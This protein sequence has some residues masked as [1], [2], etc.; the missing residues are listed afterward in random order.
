MGL[1]RKIDTA[2]A[3]SESCASLEAVLREQLDL[4]ELSYR[5]IAADIGWS[6]TQ[7]WLFHKQECKLQFDMLSS[8]ANFF[9]MPYQIQFIPS[10]YS[11]DICRSMGE[12]PAM[13]RAA[14]S[15]A[16][17]QGVSYRK[18]G[19]RTG[20][21]HEWIRCFHVKEANIEARKLMML[22]EHLSVAYEFSNVA[23]FESA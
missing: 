7:L 8:L 21:S 10:T 5:T 4:T 17:E 18:V 13:T 1:S 16:V 9:D 19:Q 23:S 2:I 12:L 20:I 3:F 15:D 22:A 11:G 14:L 6:H